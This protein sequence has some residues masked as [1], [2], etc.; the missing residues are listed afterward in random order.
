MIDEFVRDMIREFQGNLNTCLPARIESY[1]HAK[2]AASVQPLINRRLLADGGQTSES[3][4]VIPAVPVVWPRSGGASLT[5]PVKK[6]D[7]CLLVFSQ[8]SI[9][10]WKARGGQVTPD[11]GRK[12]ALSDAVAVMGVQPFVGGEYPEDNDNVRLKY[13]NAQVVLNSGNK[14]A[15]GNDTAEL[16]DL[17]DQLL[18]ALIAATT[19][20]A[21]GPQPLSSVPLFTQIKTLLATIKGEL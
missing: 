17:F 3:L 5:F 9:D 13:N 10:K 16:L 7:T 21:A 14:L 19:A 4:P 2:Q 15:I 18:D 11:D 6:G 12:H 1:D 20:T 8:R